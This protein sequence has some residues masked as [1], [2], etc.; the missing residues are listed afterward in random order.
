M[1]KFIDIKVTVWQ[2]QHLPDNVNMKAI[3]KELKAGKSVDDTLTD[4]DI[5][6]SS[7]YENET[8]LETES[9]LV[10]EENGGVATVEVWNSES[11]KKLL[12]TN[13]KSSQS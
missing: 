9:A 13:A 6:F 5:Y 1:S 7:S 8:L 2:R 4:M 10:P 12:W 3:L 11:K